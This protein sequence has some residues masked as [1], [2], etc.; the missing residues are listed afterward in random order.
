MK[1]IST[2]YEYVAFMTWPSFK[3]L[4]SYDRT[5]PEFSGAIGIKAG[6]RI[7]VRIRVAVILKVKRIST[8]L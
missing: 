8:I 7:E 3:G 2:N 4:A 6:V 5:F 1:N